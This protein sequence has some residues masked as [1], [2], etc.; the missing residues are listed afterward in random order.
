MFL[1]IRV[2]KRITRDNSY[3]TFHNVSINTNSCGIYKDGSGSFTFH[4]VSIN[5]AFTRQNKRDMFFF[6]FHNVSINTG[7][8]FY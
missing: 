2:I 7:E 1:L 4:N 6:T 8:K 5:T 3:F